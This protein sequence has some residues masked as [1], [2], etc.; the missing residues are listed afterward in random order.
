MFRPGKL[1]LQGLNPVSSYVR[2]ICIWVLVISFAL[3]QVSPTSARPFDLDLSFGI[4]GITIDV[5]RTWGPAFGATLQN[6]G[7]LLVVGSNKTTNGDRIDAC[8]TRY[9]TNGVIEKSHYQNVLNDDS[10]DFVMVQNNGKIVAVGGIT[11]S[12]ADRILIERYMPDLTVDTTFGDNGFVVTTLGQ[13]G[14]LP[15]AAAV[16]SDGKIIVGAG[17]GTVIRYNVDGTLDTTFNNDGIIET[18]LYISSISDAEI[19]AGKSST[20]GTA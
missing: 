15:S 11:G 8:I 19:C 13:N 1:T 2:Q 5:N 17:E 10:F 4:D 14:M 18:S 20:P 7:K 16:Q 9:D 6:D 12:G 3:L